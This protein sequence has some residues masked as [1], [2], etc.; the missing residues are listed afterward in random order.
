MAPNNTT[1]D[2]LSLADAIKALRVALL[3]DT[4]VNFTGP[5]GIGKSAIA[6]IIA[7][8]M[9]LP[10]ETLLLSQCDP[11]DIGGFPVVVNGKLARMPLGAIQRAC[12][13]PV[14]LFL[15][16]LSCAAPAVQGAALQLVYNRR[17]G[18]V[19][20]NPGTRIVA[21]MNPPD[22]AAGGWEIAPPLLSRMTQIKMR[23]KK[24][25]IQ[26]YFYKLGPDGS[27]MRRVAVDFAATLESAPDLLQLDPPQGT[28]TA[29]L[30]WGAPRSWERAIKFCANALENGESDTS[31]VFTA[32]LAG[33]V[34]DGA[35]AAYM[36]VRKIRGQLPGV[37]DITNDPEHAK[38]PNDINV[39]MAV[40]GVLAQV[41]VDDP[42]PAWVY[43][44][45]LKM[46]EVRVAAM[47]VLG[48]FPIKD[49]KGS[50]W[51]NGADNAM[52][53]LLKDLGKA[54]RQT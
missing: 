52:T 41:A 15:D 49:H 40:L 24:D 31:P 1:L 30:A 10:L 9:R 11:T 51:Y 4:P 46:D 50:K 22:Q 3:S 39:A 8:E 33:N 2:V 29:G 14:I 54:M 35:A 16:E 21:A 19:K 6:E 13:E 43:A 26:N 27:M 36:A 34:G 32:G 23:P 5:P 53:A 37:K 12:A 20:L 38:V 7:D 25:E 17:A 18:D 42:C 48:K 44:A 45:R 47:N 28:A